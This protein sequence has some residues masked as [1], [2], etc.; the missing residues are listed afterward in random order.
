MIFEDVKEFLQTNH[1]GVVM[2]VQPNGSV[3]SSIVVCGAFGDDLALV[4]VRG[5]SQKVKNLRRDPRCTVLAV[6]DDWRS[7]ATVEGNAT[8][9]D[10]SNTNREELRVLLREV[11]RVCGD[12][13]HPDWDEYDDAMHDQDAVVILIRPSR[14]YGLIR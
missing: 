5:S 3:Q 1:R 9:K 12:S 13:E 8:L 4:S 6:T 10:G 2:T 14:V 7:Y 11:Y